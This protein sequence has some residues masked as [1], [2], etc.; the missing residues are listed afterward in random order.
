[1][2]KA[3]C[4]VNRVTG[5]YGV[6]EENV[7]R[8]TIGTQLR[9]AERNNAEPVVNDEKVEQEANKLLNGK[10]RCMN[11]SKNGQKPKRTQRT[12][13]ATKP[14]RNLKNSNPKNKIYINLNLKLKNQH[15]LSKILHLPPI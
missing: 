2:V 14:K 3:W 5:S 6:S 4:P 11:I 8:K 12:Q 15:N 1:M 7:V 10:Y 13:N 9:K